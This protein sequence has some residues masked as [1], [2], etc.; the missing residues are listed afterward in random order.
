MTALV[1]NR[2][3][4]KLIGA[5]GVTNFA[6]G[7]ASVAFPWLATLLT[8]DPVLIGLVAFAGR[9]PWLLLVVPAGVITDRADRRRLIMQAD[10]LRLVL[11]CGV[12]SLILAFP[13]VPTPVAAMP[14]ILVLS[15]LAFLLGCAEVLRDNAAQTFMPA[16][17][18]KDDLERANGQLWSVE[19]ILGRFV[20]PPLA[21]LLIALSLPSSFLMNAVAF[22]LSALLVWLIILPPRIAPPR[23][24]WR[25]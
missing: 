9:L 18:A 20:A 17:V 5:S 22:A 10:C 8:R 3:Y 19:T 23:R 13:D 12:V 11:A 6:D 25:L 21:G 16:I 24:S 2:N 7:I 1:Q 15:A 14:F 4:L